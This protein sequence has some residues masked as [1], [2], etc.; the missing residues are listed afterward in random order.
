MET[1]INQLIG[2]LGGDHGTVAQ[3][4]AWIG[5]ARV[6]MKL[7]S[8]KLQAAMQKAINRVIETPDD[9]DDK[10]LGRIVGSTGYKIGAFLADWVFSVKLPMDMPKVHVPESHP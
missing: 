3:I 10:I 9:A 6:P 7:F 4:I 5:A 1:E 2:L 8:S